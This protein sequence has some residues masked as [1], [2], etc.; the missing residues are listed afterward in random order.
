MAGRTSFTTIEVSSAQRLKPPPG[1]NER[2][3]ACFIKLIAACPASKFEQSDLALLVRFIELQ[4]LCEDAVKQIDADGAVDVEGA[5]SAW[6]K[7]YLAASK[8][9]ATMAMRLQ[10]C[11]STRA[12]KAPK[13]AAAPMSAYE[14]LAL[15]D[16]DADADTKP[17]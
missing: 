6:M 16:D 11:P 10:L 14:L 15:E 8:N 4:L 7:I 3:R 5:P 2:Q 1:L 12:P 13:V 9:L 17:S